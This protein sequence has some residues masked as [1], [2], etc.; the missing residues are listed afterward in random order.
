MDR[1]HP[2]LVRIS[3]STPRSLPIFSAMAHTFGHSYGAVAALLAAARRTEAVWSLTAIESGS[4]S[5]ARG[6]PIVDEFELRLAA[7]AEAPPDDPAERLRVLL[8]IVKPAPRLSRRPS[9]D[10]LNFVRRLR[11]FHW[12]QEAVIPVDV[13]A[14]APFSK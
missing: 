12:P 1:A 9:P 2:R 10:I 13:L 11:S 6:N 7:L 4:S 5:V 8:E 14:A 3:M